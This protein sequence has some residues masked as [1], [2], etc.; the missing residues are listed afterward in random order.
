[1]TAARRGGQIAP[2]DRAA[3]LSFLVECEACDSPAPRL[4][5]IAHFAVSEMED[6]IV[7]RGSSRGRVQGA[8][9]LLGGFRSF[10]QIPQWRGESAVQF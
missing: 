10:L 2:R 1:M 8:T 3:G 9:D 7:Q 4:R 6:E 5:T